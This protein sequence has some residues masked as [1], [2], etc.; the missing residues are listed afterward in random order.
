MAT[1]VQETS[2]SVADEPA[3]S[4]MFIPDDELIAPP[5]EPAAQAEGDESEQAAVEAEGGEQDEVVSEQPKGDPDKQNPGKKIE[6]LNYE[7]LGLK[8]ALEQSGEMTRSAINEALKPLM[9]Q[10]AALKSA[11]QPSARQAEPAK[12]PEPDVDPLSIFKDRD[13]EEVVSVSDMKSLFAGQKKVLDSALS[14]QREELQKEFSKSLTDA[15]I[16]PRKVEEIIE[17]SLGRRD[18]QAAQVV[19]WKASYAENYGDLNSSGVTA[20]Q[21]LQEYN[22]LLNKLMPSNLSGDDAQRVA[23]A[24]H[25]EVVDKLRAKASTKTAP[26]DSKPAI[27]QPKSP[28]GTQTVS[29]G[30]SASRASGS[31][32]AGGKPAMWVPD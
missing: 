1:E 4:R 29:S 24:I 19:A 6:K 27:R 15:G 8:R 26:T 20:D 2:T 22:Q 21:F 9:D 25:D 18:Q 11:D 14:R 28:V 30:T 23:K 13:E 5:T 12:E 31:R 16:D 10:L 17:N 3:P 32:P 7:V